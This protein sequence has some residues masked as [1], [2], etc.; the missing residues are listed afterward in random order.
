MDCTEAI[1]EELWENVHQDHPPSETYS[2]LHVQSRN[3]STLLVLSGSVHVHLPPYLAALSLEVLEF[4][5]M[6]R[7]T[8]ST[9]DQ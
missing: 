8:A 4:W 6:H 2:I 5:P 7:R 9:N 1:K 3:V